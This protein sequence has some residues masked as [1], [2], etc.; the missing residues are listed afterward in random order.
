MLSV[1]MSAS[2]SYFQVHLSCWWDALCGHTHTQSMEIQS[3]LVF[4]IGKVMAGGGLG[5]RDME[6]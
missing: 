5:D 2:N 4:V 1:L 6:A 3:V